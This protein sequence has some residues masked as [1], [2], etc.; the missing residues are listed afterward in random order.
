MLITVINII[1]EKRVIKLKAITNSLNL[2]RFEKLSARV[3]VVPVSGQ[4]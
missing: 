2:E 1:N 4:N 3:H